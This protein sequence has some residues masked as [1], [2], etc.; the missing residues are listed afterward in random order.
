[1][2]VDIY[3]CDLTD[4]ASVQ[5]LLSTLDEKYK[6]SMV[7][8][9][10][11]LGYLKYAKDLSESEINQMLQLNLNTLI[12]ITQHFVPR[13]IEDKS[14]VIVNIASQAGKSA[15]VKSSVY[16]ATKFGVLGYSNALRLELK[17]YGIHV[18][19]VNPGP[20]ATDFFDK[21]EPTG[22]YLE[23]LGAV[24]LDPVKVAEE[25]VKGI[26]KE[27]REINLPKT[28][29]F[30]SKLNVLFPKIGDKLLGSIFNK[31]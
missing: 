3:S 28:M 6:I 24:V 7:I 22:K 4:D 31:K 15:T 10:A 25:V 29:N 13:F 26:E 20:I 30:G 1:K 11:G 16:S 18:M 9:N 19:T 27:K 23:Q 17:P 21:A 2:P 14:G 8:N 5:D 12:K